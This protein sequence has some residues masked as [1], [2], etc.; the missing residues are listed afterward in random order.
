MFFLVGFPERIQN[1]DFNLDAKK[2]R[3]TNFKGKKD[4][5]LTVKQ[6]RMKCDR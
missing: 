5:Q 1:Q 2:K 3:E 4:T 6:E